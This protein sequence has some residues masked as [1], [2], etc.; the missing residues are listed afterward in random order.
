MSPTSSDSRN[1]NVA[2]LQFVMFRQWLQDPKAFIY[3]PLFMQGHS[4]VVVFIAARFRS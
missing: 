2:R 3:P 4:S 1:P